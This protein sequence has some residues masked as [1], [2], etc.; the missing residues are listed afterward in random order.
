MLMAEEELIYHR[1]SFE[2]ENGTKNERRI[3]C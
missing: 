3:M 1:K 2:G